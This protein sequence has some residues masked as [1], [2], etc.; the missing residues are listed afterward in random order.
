MTGSGLELPKR[1]IHSR[2]Q[3]SPVDDIAHYPEADDAAAF[4]KEAELIDDLGGIGARG[5]LN[6]INSPGKK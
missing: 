3:Q 2:A 1:R 4:K 6:R 5:L